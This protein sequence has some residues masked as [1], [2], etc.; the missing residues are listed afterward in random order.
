MSLTPI[1]STKAEYK[2]GETYIAGNTGFVG[3]DIIFVNPDSR[4]KPL[5]VEI[6]YS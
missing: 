2:V 5:S 1:H 6:S 4:L 3:V